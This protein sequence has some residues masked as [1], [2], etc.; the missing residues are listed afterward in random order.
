MKPEIKRRLDGLFEAF[1]IIAEGRYVYLCDMEE[2]ISRWSEK[3]VEY[4]DLP[5]VYMENAG[6]IWA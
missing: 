6:A 4:F 2:D 5:D 1:S 3:A